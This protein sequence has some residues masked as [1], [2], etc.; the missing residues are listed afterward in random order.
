MKYI[1]A[2]KI[3]SEGLKNILVSSD[4]F[5]GKYI[6]DNLVIPTTQETFLKS[7]IIALFLSKSIL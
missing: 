1:V 2:K 5:L 4:Y 6:K 7:A 3:Y